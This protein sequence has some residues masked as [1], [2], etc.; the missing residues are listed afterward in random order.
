M[1]KF[2]VGA[3]LALTMIAAPIE[4]EAAELT[5][6]SEFEPESRPMQLDFVLD[7]H[8]RSFFGIFPGVFFAFPVAPTGFISSLN[9][10]FYIEGGI[11]AGVWFAP[12]FFWMVPQA[13][14]R[15]VFYLTQEWAVFGALRAGAGIEFSDDVRSRHYTYPYV[16]LSVGAHWHFSE[17]LAL[18]LET[19][20]GIFGWHG[21]VGLS[22]QL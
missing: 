18:R 5:I 19:G 16:A 14:V 2:W 8:A 21:I 9:D 13:G 4:G 3:A 6:K 1:R 20:G 11:V 7:L 17:T 15:W 22:I 10:A 12:T